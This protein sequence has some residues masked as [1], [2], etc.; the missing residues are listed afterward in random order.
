LCRYQA[1]DA[2]LDAGTEAVEEWLR[3]IGLDGRLQA[4]RDQGIEPEQL[5]E[6][7]DGDLRELGLTIGERKRFRRAITSDPPQPP[8]SEPSRSGLV[9]DATLA[10]RRPLTV[11]FVDLVNSSGIAEQLEPEDLL[12]LIRAYRAFC[13]AAVARYGGRVARFT[14]DGILTYFS[15][16]VAHENDPERAVRAAIKIVQGISAVETA[17]E[18]PLR[19]RIGIATGRVIVS[20]LL[21]GDETEQ[22]SIVGSTPNLAARLQGFAPGNGIVIASETQSRIAS[23]FEFEDMGLCEVRGFAAPHRTWRVLRELPQAE[24]RL[25]LTQPERLTPVYGRQLELELLE[26]HWHRATEGSGRVILL[27]GEAGIGKSRLIEHFLAQV[28]AGEPHVGQLAGSQINEDSPFHPLVAHLRELSGFSEIDDP[29]A[30][31]ARL[32]ATIPGS[33]EEQAAMAPVLAALIG[34]P[35]AP[36]TGLAPEQL[37]ER[38]LV[39]LLR[40]LLGAAA[41]GPACLVVEDLH[42]MDPSTL[43]LLSRLVGAVREKSL[44]L[45]MTT[46]PEFDA[47]WLHGPDVTVLGLERLRSGDI[48]AMVRN[49][50]GDRPAPPELLRR[51]A[52]KTDGVPLFVEELLR[53]LLQEKAGAGAELAEAADAI[54]ASLHESLMSRLDRAGAAKQIAQNASVLGR[55][56]ALPILAAISDLPPATLDDGLDTLVAAGVLVRAGGIRRD[57]FAFSHALLRDAA[58]DSLLRDRKRQLHARVAQALETLAPDEIAEQ[59]ETM[60][61]HLTEGGEAE[62][63]A[64]YWQEAARR[65]LARSALTEATRLLRRGLA[66]LQKVP[67]SPRVHTLRLELSGLLGPALMALRGPGAPETQELYNTAHNLARQLPED[68]SHYPIYWGWWRVSRDYHTMLRRSASL[69]SKARDRGQAE[70]MLQSHHCNWASHYH[71]GDFAACCAHAEAGLAIYHGGDFRHHAS[72]YGNHDPKACA[73]GELALVAWM[74][75]RAKTALAEEA[76]CIDWATGLDHLGSQVHAM[77][78]RLLH[79][80]KRRDYREVFGR[81]TELVSFTSEH[82][83]ADH[84]AKGLIFRG[85]T[86]AVQEDPEAGLAMLE[87]GFA[88]QQDIG[89]SEDFPIYV[90]LLAEA[91]RAA[92]RADRAVEALVKARVGFEEAGLAVWMPEVIRSTAES[93]LAADH[94][95]QEAALALIDEAA[96][97]AETQDVPMLGLRIATS[98]ARLLSSLEES[99]PALTTLEAARAGLPEPMDNVDIRE[100]ALLADCLRERLGLPRTPDPVTAG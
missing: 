61:H 5:A 45:V 35:D 42:W 64:H 13:G 7:T 33:E 10:E 92:G 78:L 51:I 77:D 36:P 44:L 15:Y 11:M 43:E 91:L 30:R 70:F 56:T 76:R 21:A 32:A 18:E 74:Q 60:A 79:R 71:V 26:R 25:R 12:E 40:H 68:P 86:V 16:P 93:M 90:C 17:A 22:Q 82:G 48:A 54:P 39:A 100:A 2:A 41:K 20:D 97:L 73:H 27:R 31:L 65:S 47:P 75:G 87:E 62:A 89:T 28:V 81:A 14:G 57:G 6:L 67:A 3:A 52:A 55:S 95:A 34:I 58:Y 37:R 94:G 72:L 29:E 80:V 96:R 63:A 98:C 88:M 9:I 24:R 46:R 99:Q 4:F 49:L 85:W 53:S 59:P 38:T 83:L 66:A 19:V 23:L 1:C 50:L 8:L 84:R 69:H